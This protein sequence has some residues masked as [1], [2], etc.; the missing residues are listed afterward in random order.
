MAMAMMFS[1]EAKA[2]QSYKFIKCEHIGR[3]NLE[4]RSRKMWAQQTLLF[5][6]MIAV[7]LFL[8]SCVLTIIHLLLYSIKNSLSHKG[9]QEF[10]HG[11]KYKTA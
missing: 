3:C 5:M 9:L 4:G 8:R 11:R 2:I 6:I 1:L 7:G 10:Y